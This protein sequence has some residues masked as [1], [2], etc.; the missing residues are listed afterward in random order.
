VTDLTDAVLDAEFPDVLGVLRGAAVEL[1]AAVDPADGGRIW[2]LVLAGARTRPL[3]ARRTGACDDA[4][5]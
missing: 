1:H 2:S 5:A 3:P 4:T